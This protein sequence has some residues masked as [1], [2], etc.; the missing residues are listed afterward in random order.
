MGAKAQFNLQYESGASQL[1]QEMAQLKTDFALAGIAIN[2]STAPFDTVIGNATPQSHTWDME[3]WGAGWIYAPDY[4]PTGDELWSC[5]GSGASVQYAGS[6]SGGYCD[7]QAESDILATETSSNV[8]TM[9]T[10]EDY[11]AKQLP[12][13][14]LPVSEAQL[15]EINKDLQGT[16]PQD[17]LL[18]IYP[19]NWRWS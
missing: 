4:E 1:D 8:Q 3:Y 11:L 18:Q 13:I 9:Y 12:V 15:S 16:G 17:P 7:P 6:D 10:Y 2:L 14:W 5:T 19:E